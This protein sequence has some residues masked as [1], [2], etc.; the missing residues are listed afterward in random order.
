MMEEGELE[1]GLMTPILGSK[2]ALRLSK[3]KMID[4]QMRWRDGNPSSVVKVYP[5]GVPAPPPFFVL[6][7]VSFQKP[8]RGPLLSFLTLTRTR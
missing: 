4:L 8:K 3:I 1:K 5:L 2:L 6:L 7:Q